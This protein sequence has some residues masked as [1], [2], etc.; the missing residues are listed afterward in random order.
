MRV[1]AGRPAS[2]RS[3][4]DAHRAAPGVPSWCSMISSTRPGRSSNGRPWAGSTSC[5]PVD[6]RDPVQRGEEL[7]RARR[8]PGSCPEM[9][10][11]MLGRTW[12]P[13]SSVP[14]SG[15]NRQMWSPVWPGVCTTCHSRRPEA[16]A[17]R[18]RPPGRS[19]RATAGPP[20]TGRP[21]VRMYSSSP[22]PGRNPSS[23]QGVVRG[24]DVGQVAGRR[25]A[26]RASRWLTGPVP[27]PGRRSRSSTSSSRSPSADCRH[28]A[29]SWSSESAGG[30]TGWRSPRGRPRRSGAPPSADRP[31]RSGRGASG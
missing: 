8:A 29:R 20:W 30:R 11:V 10:G 21:S 1:V 6:A 25:R 24:G 17:T 31:R 23:P 15:S 28:R 18:R 7:A 5:T 22:A 16:D 26:R 14:C 12:S 19:G 13:E 2:P 3:S 9:C 4:A 27:E